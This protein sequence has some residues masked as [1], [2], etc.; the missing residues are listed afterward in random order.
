MELGSVT[1][2]LRFYPTSMLISY[3]A[4]FIDTGR[5]MTHN[6]AGSMSVMF[7]SVTLAPTV[8]WD[9]EEWLKWMLH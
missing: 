8:L 3:P 1:K 5:I 4:S 6:T 7:A 9:H 2:G